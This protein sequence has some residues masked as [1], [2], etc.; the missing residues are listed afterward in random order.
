MQKA[1]SLQEII[2]PEQKEGL[3]FSGNFADYELCEKQGFLRLTD[4]VKNRDGLVLV[5]MRSKPGNLHFKDRELS[6]EDISQELQK[7]SQNMQ[8]EAKEQALNQAPKRSLSQEQVLP[9][10]PSKPQIHTHHSAIWGFDF[11]FAS[12]LHIK[13]KDIKITVKGFDEHNDMVFC[14]LDNPPSVSYS[15]ELSSSELSMSLKGENAGL[16]LPHYVFR[17]RRGSRGQTRFFYIYS[18]GELIYEQRLLIS[19]RRPF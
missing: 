3:Y 13:S 11:H 4:S 14:D 10:K 19:I 9:L 2:D 16:L 12:D 17:G 5:E 1:Y 15:Y 18:H 8:K 7:A 6:L